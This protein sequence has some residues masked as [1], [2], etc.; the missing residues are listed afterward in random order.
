MLD[1]VSMLED[2][3]GRGLGRGLVRVAEVPSCAQPYVLHS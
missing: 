3:N 1:V 2:E